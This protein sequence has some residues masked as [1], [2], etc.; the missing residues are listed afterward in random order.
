MD[1]ATAI[2]F[3]LN[4]LTEGSFNENTSQYHLSPEFIETLCLRCSHQTLIEEQDGLLDTLR[5]FS[6]YWYNTTLTNTIDEIHQFSQLIVLNP[7]P[8]AFYEDLTELLMRDV[9]ENDQEAKWWAH[10]IIIACCGKTHLYSDMGF[11]G[12]GIISALFRQHFPLLAN[13]N[14]GNKMRWKKFIYRQFCLAEQLPLCPAA[15]CSECP[16]RQEC[17]T[18]N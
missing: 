7:G 14:I 13:K 17:Y 1:Q 3:Y 9:A 8:L 15:S 12:R 10:K 18:E 6:H 2:T 4:G 5:S 11:K 16:S